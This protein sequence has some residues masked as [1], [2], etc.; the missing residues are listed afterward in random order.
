MCAGLCVNLSFQLNKININL[1]VLD[2]M[3][4]RYSVVW[5][6]KTV[7]QSGHTI[8]ISTSNESSWCSTSLSAFDVVSILNYI[9]PSKYVVVSYSLF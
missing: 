9:Y 4:R 6:H 5:D 7:F 2:Y 3:G 8:C 1:Y